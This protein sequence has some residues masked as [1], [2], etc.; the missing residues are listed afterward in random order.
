NKHKGNYGEMKMDVHF[1]SQGYERINIDRVTSLDDKVVKGIDGVYFDPGPPPK[2][3]IGE[4]K[5]G[6]SNLSQTKD[7]KQ[8]SDTWVE[9]KNRLEK[10]V[11]KDAADD[12]LLEGYDK[13]L[14]NTKEDGTVVSKVLDAKG[15]IKK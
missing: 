13:V 3:I 8:M 10:A 15:N 4:A 7:G 2:Y 6:S 5:Y 1:E 9:G 11:G 12:I 14:V